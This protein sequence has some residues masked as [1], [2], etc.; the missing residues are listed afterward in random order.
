MSKNPPISKLQLGR[1]RGFDA[2]AALR[3]AIDAFWE[4]GF[5]ATSLDD[6]C[7]AMGLNR[8]SFYACFGSKHALFMAAV[9]LYADERFALLGDQTRSHADPLA[10]VRAMICS[11]WVTPYPRRCRARPMT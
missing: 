2:D 7:R 11:S 10:A 8:S 3:V 4:H 1:P 5:E 6:L 9:R